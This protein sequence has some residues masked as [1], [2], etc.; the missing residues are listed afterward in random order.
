LLPSPA[1]ERLG[2]QKREGEQLISG[3][4]FKPAREVTISHR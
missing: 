3:Q 2:L 1:A 4:L